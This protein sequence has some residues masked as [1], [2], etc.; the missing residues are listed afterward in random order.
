MKVIL[1][2]G[3]Q[4]RSVGRIDLIAKSVLC[5]LIILRPLCFE[6]N[7]IEKFNRSGEMKRWKYGFQR[8]V[9]SDRLNFSIECQCQHNVNQYNVAKIKPRGKR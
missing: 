3:R 9:A 4:A 5:G 8:L 2:S 7:R 1:I 6:F